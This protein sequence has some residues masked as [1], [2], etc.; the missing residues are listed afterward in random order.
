MQEDNFHLVDSRPAKPVNRFGNRRFQQNKFQQQRAQ[1]E[2]E[3]DGGKEADKKKPQQQKK[4]PWQW[5]GNREQQRV[6]IVLCL[7]SAWFCVCNQHG[8]VCGVA[9]E[10]LL[11]VH[12]LGVC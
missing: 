5:Q 3:R 10:Q 8:C 12:G 6:R 11:L 4:N 7:Q 9:A 2:R 1:R